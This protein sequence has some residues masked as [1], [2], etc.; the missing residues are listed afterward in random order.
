[1][2]RAASTRGGI[3]FGGSHGLVVL[4][5]RNFLLV[6]ELLVA[7]QIVLRLDVVGLGLVALGLGRLELLSGSGDAG[8]GAV[9]VGLGGRYLTVGA[10]RS[11]GN[12]NSRFGGGCLGALEIG[13]SALVG[14]LV[15]R[16]IDFYQHGARLHV[17][18]VQ[19]IQLHDVARNAGADGVDVA[20]DLGIIRGFVTGDIAVD[21]NSRHQQ[22]DGRNAD[23]DTKAGAGGARRASMEV[24]LR[25]G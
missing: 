9:D 4:L 10:D 16:R 12:I 18:I 6:D 2:A 13:F 19:D 15:I 8:T 25:G 20:V 17:L 1:M 22:H 5:L 24:P 3:G 23:C 21:E 11:D 14:N 7:S